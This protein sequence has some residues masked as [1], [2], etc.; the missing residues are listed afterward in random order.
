[1]KFTFSVC[2]Y[3]DY[4]AGILGFSLEVSVTIFPDH[5]DDED[6]IEHLRESITEYYDGARVELMNKCV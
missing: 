1:M 6:F 2:E 3:P 5:L 4:S